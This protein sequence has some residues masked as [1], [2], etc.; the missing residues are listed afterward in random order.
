MHLLQKN[1]QDSIAGIMPKI[2]QV[3]NQLVVNHQSFVRHLQD[4][5]QWSLELQKV[6]DQ[7]IQHHYLQFLSD[8]KV[9]RDEMEILKRPWYTHV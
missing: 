8:L 4:Q 2:S 7:K 6:L 5:R 3:I 9:L 1:V